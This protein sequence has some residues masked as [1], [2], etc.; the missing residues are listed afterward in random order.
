M[1]ESRDHGAPLGG[2]SFGRQPVD[3]SGPTYVV[4]TAEASHPGTLAIAGYADAVPLHQGGQ[5]IVYKAFQESTRRTVAIKV[6]SGGASASEAARRRFQREVEIA[7]QLSHPHIVAVFDSGV[8][9]DG[10]PYLVMEYLD[11]R[12]L[13]AHIRECGLSLSEALTLCLPVLDAVDFA[14]RNGVIH[15]DLKPSNILVDGSGCPKVVDF[16]LARALFADLERSLSVAGQVLGTFAYMSPE[17]V[18]GRAEAIDFRTDV[19]SLGIILYE[20]CTGRSPYPTDSQILELLR[21][22]A[23]TPPESP[24]RAWQPGSGIA[25]RSR[26]SEGSAPVCPIDAPLETL[27]LRAIAK[28]PA[29]R[30]ASVNDLAQDLRAY[31][32]GR[33]IVARPL[34]DGIASLPRSLANSVNSVSERTRRRR[35]ALVATSGLL[36]ALVL[37]GLVMARFLEP[38]A[39]VPIPPP[40]PNPSETAARIRFLAGETEYAEVREQLLSELRARKAPDGADPLANESLRIVQDA[41]RELRAALEADPS[42]ESLQ[43]LLLAN[44]QREIRLLRRMCESG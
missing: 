10:L 5:G 20:I 41:V 25:E 27:L 39:T 26:A 14:H 35:R 3:P 43:Q 37:I 44:Y 28:D 42:N 7:A 2:S 21:H 18:R 36:G 8:T 22:I 24:R 38:R 11:G 12:T 13:D 17:Q 16:G 40:L 4:G 9:A 23:E 6:L 30:Y 15:R 19:Y 29:R 1:N 32:E 33:P 31:L 34:T